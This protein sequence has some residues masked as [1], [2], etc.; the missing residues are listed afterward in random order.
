[1]ENFSEDG[2]SEM[3]KML[4]PKN[5]KGA[6][7]KFIEDVEKIRELENKKKIVEDWFMEHYNELPIFDGP[8]KE[9]EWNGDAKEEFEDKKNELKHYIDEIHKYHDKHLD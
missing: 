3:G 9:R 1:M 7:G 4:E 6:T 5:T 2:M 8:E